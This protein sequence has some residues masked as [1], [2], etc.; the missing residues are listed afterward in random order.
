MRGGTTSGPNDRNPAPS[1]RIGARV[2]TS[3]FDQGWRIDYLSRAVSPSSRR[4]AIGAEWRVRPVAG[5]IQRGQRYR[6]VRRFTPAGCLILGGG[7]SWGQTC[8]VSQIRYSSSSCGSRSYPSRSCLI[9]VSLSRTFSRGYT[10]ALESTHL[11][12]SRLGKLGTASRL[13]P[14]RRPEVSQRRI[15]VPFPSVFRARAENQR[16]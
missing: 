4:T 8:S 9:N 1:T 3:A 15:F 6:D 16:R 12:F 7:S 2:S 14:P 5:T 11:R 13:I 10:E